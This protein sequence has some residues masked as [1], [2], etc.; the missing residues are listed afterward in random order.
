LESLD[1]GGMDCNTTFFWQQKIAHVH[2]SI[3]HG[4]NRIN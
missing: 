2:S 4:N 3:C 1:T